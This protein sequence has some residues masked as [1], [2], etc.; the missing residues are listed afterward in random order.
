MRGRIRR[1]LVQGAL[2]ALLAALACAT[3]RAEAAP[4]EQLVRHGRITWVAGLSSVGLGGVLMP[5]QGALR[6]YNFRGEWFDKPAYDRAYLRRLD[7]ADGLLGTGIGLMAGGY[8]VFVAGAM[9]EGIGMRKAL[10][11]PSWPG[12][13]GMS[14][15]SASLITVPFGGVSFWAIPGVIGGPFA[16]VALG[17]TIAQLVLDG[18]ALR[19][20]SPERRQQLLQ[21]RPKVYV[22]MAPTVRTDGGGLSLVG[23]W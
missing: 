7:V 16:G 10:G 17:F 4:G 14:V 22:T 8:T 19:R 20:I 1:A 2:W 12:I 6:T 21:A 5:V 23:I 18:R 13:V 11:V 15:F 9:V 3:P